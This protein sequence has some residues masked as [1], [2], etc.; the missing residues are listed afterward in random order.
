MFGEIRYVQPPEPC[1]ELCGFSSHPKVL[2]G[3]TRPTSQSAPPSG[4]M[5]LSPQEGKQLRFGLGIS[6]L[7]VCL[8][9]CSPS[10]SEG[11]SAPCRRPDGP[12]SRSAPATRQ[13]SRRTSTLRPPATRHTLSSAPRNSAVPAA[14]SSPLSP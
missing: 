12:R 4:T 2:S 9:A 10:V 13:H 5:L 11:G 14:P 7:S 1:H 3:H 6:C 8:P